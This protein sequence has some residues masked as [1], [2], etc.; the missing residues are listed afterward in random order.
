MGSFE[1]PPSLEAIHANRYLEREWNQGRDSK[2]F[3]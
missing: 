2:G 3:R 1:A